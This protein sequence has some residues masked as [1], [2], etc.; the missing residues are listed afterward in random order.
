MASDCLLKTGETEMSYGS[1]GRVHRDNWDDSRVE[2]GA[3]SCIEAW[4]QKKT[5]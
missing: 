2:W 4:N 3:P 5:I 1:H